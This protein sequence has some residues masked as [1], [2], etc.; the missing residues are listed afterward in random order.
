MRNVHKVFSPE[1]KGKEKISVVT[2]YDF[3][4]ARILGETEIDSI[5][6]GDSLGMVIQGN[7]S[8]LPVTLEEMIYHT[9]AVRRG[10]PDKFIVADLPFLSYQT[11]IEEGIRSAGKMMKET[12]CDAV[13]IEGGSDFICELVAIL[14]QIGVPVMGHLGLTPQSVHVFGGHKVQGKGEESGAKLLKEAIALGESGA[15]SMVLEM[16][17]AELGKKVSQSIGVPTIGIGA[18]PDCDGQVLV[19]NDLLGMDPN[20]QPK[21][22]KKFS[23]LH[24]IVKDAVGN[25]NK[26]VKS[27]EFPGKDHSF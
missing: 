22:L 23:N 21:F 13:K 11:S 9:K 10:A 7:S 19:L 6:V 16:I 20:F 15:F 25:Y 5:L 4:F 27:E 24:S 26:E 17:P 14:K 3:S 8:T 2:C 1:K 12:D 18:G